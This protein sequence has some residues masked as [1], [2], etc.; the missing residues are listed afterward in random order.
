MIRPGAIVDHQDKCGHNPIQLCVHPG[1]VTDDS[2]V[3]GNKENAINIADVVK[4]L[5]DNGIVVNAIDN[6]S[7][8]P[9]H[10]AVRQR[11]TQVIETLLHLGSDPSLATKTGETAVH[12]ATISTTS[13]NIIIDHIMK[14][15]TAIDLNVAD[16]FGSK[17]LHWAVSLIEHGSGK[18]LL[19]EDCLQIHDGNRSSPADLACL[20]RFASLYESLG[21]CFHR[22]VFPINFEISP[23]R[24]D[25]LL[26]HLLH[27]NANMLT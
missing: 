14:T 17:P 21:I 16:N 12:R 20:F 19:L 25:Y 9:L 22:G 1:V 6:D 18:R 2:D 5:V 23:S 13:L 4:V 11:N 27:Q 7:F 3:V 15:N 24:Y 26:T 8:T 10:F